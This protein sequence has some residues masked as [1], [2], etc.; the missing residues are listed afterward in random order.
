MTTVS[1]S[2][3]GMYKMTNH[4]RLGIQEGDLEQTGALKQR[5]DTELQ[6]DSMTKRMF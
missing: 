6:Q 2:G 1:G 4:K 5:G 3:T